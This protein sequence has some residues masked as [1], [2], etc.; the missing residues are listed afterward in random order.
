[1]TN[2]FWL[3]AISGTKLPKGLTLVQQNNSATQ[4]RTPTAQASTDPLAVHLIENR[5]C[6]TSAENIEAINGVSFVI[7]A[8]K[9]QTKETKLKIC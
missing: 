7:L 9:F 1:M 2:P 4:N 8:K 3:E 6:I 5:L